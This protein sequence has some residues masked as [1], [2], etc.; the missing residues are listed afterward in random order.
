LGLVPVLALHAL[1][2]GAAVGRV[3]HA[4]GHAEAAAAGVAA[5]GAVGAGAGSQGDAGA[6]VVGTG[7]AARGIL[8]AGARDIRHAAVLTNQTRSAL[9]RVAHEAAAG[10]AELTELRVIEGHGEPGRQRVRRIGV[11]QLERIAGKL[12]L[13]A[14]DQVAVVVEEADEAVG[15]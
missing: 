13:V 5:G 4:A 15:A 12:V 1:H 3:R 2:D 14:V 10:V 11:L 8:N 9:D 7:V 6:A